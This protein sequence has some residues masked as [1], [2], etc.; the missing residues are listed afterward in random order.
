MH[1]FKHTVR[2]KSSSAECRSELDSVLEPL[3]CSNAQ[4][5]YPGRLY[6]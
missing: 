2:T 6:E 5:H 1:A 4:L 3:R